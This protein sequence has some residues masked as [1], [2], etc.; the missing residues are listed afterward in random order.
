MVEVDDRQSGASTEFIREGR[1]A[2]P[3][4]PDDGYSLHVFQSGRPPSPRART[5]DRADV[6]IGHALATTR[7]ERDV[8]ATLHYVIDLPQVIRN[9]ANLAGA[10]AWVDD[11]DDLVAELAR[12]WSITI[13]R[14]YEGGTEAFVAEAVLDDGR[15]A[16][17][18]LLIPREGDAGEHEITTLALVNGDACPE[19]LRCDVTRG[20]MLLE[21]LGPSLFDLGVPLHERHEILCDVAQRVWRP[22]PDCGLPTGS[23]KAAWL[24]EFITTTW[25]ALN[26]TC[27]EQAIEYA[28]A[29]GERR[30]LA[31]DDETAV[32]VHG[33]V[34]QWNCLRADV[35]FKLVDPDGL[36]A[37]AEYDMGIVMRE[38]PLELL[39]GNAHDRAQWLAKRCDLDATA[40]WEWG[41]VE[42]VSTGLLC[43]QVDLQPV[44]REM[45]AVAEKVCE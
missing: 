31:H 2:R 17:L 36:L 30:A 37:E 26:R 7:D 39:K 42:R 20:A 35:G 22:A 27:S 28:I 38:D 43:T 10:S 4:R 6:E 45:L 13:G 15:P 1:L 25:E 19:L 34:H 44:G 14:T 5:T 41:V 21:R 12:E 3:A 18:K 23:T 8:R 29:C 24:M 40:I 33:D 32:L 9:K 16:V 11:L